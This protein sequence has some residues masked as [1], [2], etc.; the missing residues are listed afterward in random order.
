MKNQIETDKIIS[1]TYELRLYHDEKV[2]IIEN[3]EKERNDYI[4]KNNE[5]VK[6]INEYKLLIDKNNSDKE[7]MLLESDRKIKILENN[8]EKER[9]DYIR[10]NNE[11]TNSINQYKILIDKSNSE[12]KQ[13]QIDYEGKIKSIEEIE[14]NNNA[15]IND[16]LNKYK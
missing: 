14:R 3:L 9:S 8:F 6:F 15:K 2:K 4:R 11:L 10:K 5:Q 12:K 16:E 1:E 7:Q 13:L